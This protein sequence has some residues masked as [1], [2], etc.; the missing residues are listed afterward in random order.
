MLKYWKI[1]KN[2]F[3]NK[4]KFLMIKNNNIYNNRLL[5]LNNY[6]KIFKKKIFKYKI[7]KYNHSLN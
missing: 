4:N 1:N 6:N 7:Y 3:K 5:K 2:I